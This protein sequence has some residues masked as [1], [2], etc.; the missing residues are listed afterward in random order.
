[1]RVIG[2]EVPELAVEIESPYGEENKVQL[3]KFH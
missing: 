3:F 1:M 2:E